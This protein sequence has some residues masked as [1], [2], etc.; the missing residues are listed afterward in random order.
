MNRG[1]FEEGE[2][3]STVSI[4]PVLSL[5]IPELHEILPRLKVM[6]RR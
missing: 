6:R 3:L 5:D 1:F 4:Y 2:K